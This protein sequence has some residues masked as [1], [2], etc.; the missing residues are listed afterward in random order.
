MSLRRNLKINEMKAKKVS[1]APLPTVDKP[2]PTV[3][4]PSP[5]VDTRP[6]TP[7]NKPDIPLGLSR[8]TVDIPDQTFYIFVSDVKLNDDVRNKFKQLNI[9]IVEF[10]FISFQN[11]KLNDLDIKHIWLNISNIKAN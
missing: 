2:P 11:K 4:I 5:T 3:D 9:N 10:N 1:F 6:L 8:P 7:A